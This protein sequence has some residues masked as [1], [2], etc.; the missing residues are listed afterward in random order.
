[1][2]KAFFITG[3]DT[4]VGKTLVSSALL[5]AFGKQGWKTAGM[6]PVAAGC[7][8][9]NG[10]LL[11]EDV[12]MLLEAGNTKAGCEL[13]NPY[14]FAPP[15][16]PHIAAEAANVNIRP[17]IIHDA[18]RELSALADVV[19]VEGVGG[20]RVPLGEQFDTADL[21]QMLNLPVILVVGMRLGCINH[22]LLTVETIQARGLEL[23]GWVAN[24][25]D[26]EM[27]VFQENLQTLDQHIAAPCLGVLPH[28]PEADFRQAAEYL[29]LTI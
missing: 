20:F 26:P 1:M 5:Y 15:I 4:G 23:A 14:A 25:I 17:R 21:A 7:V 11:S 6:K 16:A 3:T 2:K 19:I 22:A 12:A 10:R 28:L 9:E 29:Q 18:Y 8:E 27:S 13:H 24:R